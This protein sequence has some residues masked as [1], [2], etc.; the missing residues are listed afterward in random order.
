MSCVILLSE[1]SEA[2]VG[3]VECEV[4]R[5]PDLKASFSFFSKR[6]FFSK[7]KKGEKNHRI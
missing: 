4:G 7:L 5:L 3:L 1:L 6:T 2:G